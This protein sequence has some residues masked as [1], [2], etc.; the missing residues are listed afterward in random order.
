[1]VLVSIDQW[2]IV[3]PMTRLQL[4][5]KNLAHPTQVKQN[6]LKH[7]RRV[8][9]PAAGCMSVKPRFTGFTASVKSDFHIVFWRWIYEEPMHNK[10][11]S[12]YT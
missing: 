11:F 12:S 8:P 9:L 4:S 2:T 10:D 3:H 5:L 1:M 6:G 7:G